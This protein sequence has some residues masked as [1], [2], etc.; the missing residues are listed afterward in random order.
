MSDLI[1]KQAVIDLIEMRISNR[2]IYNESGSNWSRNAEATAIALAVAEMSPVYDMDKV[3][4]QLESKIDP[5]EDIDTG[6]PCYNWVVDMQ[7]DLISECIKI[8]LGG[9]YAEE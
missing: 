4:E 6:E 9:S 2:S 3:I 8:V 7:N 5:N 1:S